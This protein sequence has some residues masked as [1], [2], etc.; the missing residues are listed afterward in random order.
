MNNRNKML[1]MMPNSEME[2]R[3]RNEMENRFR[4]RRGREHYNN[5]RYAPRR[6]SAYD[7]YGMEDAYDAYD[8]EGYEMEERYEMEEMEGYG[9]GGMQPIGFSYNEM[10]GYNRNMGGGGKGGKMERGG[11]MGEEE[12]LTKR[13]ITEWLKNMKNADGSKGAH[14]QM[15]QTEQIRKQHNIEC[16]PADFSIAMN[17]MYSD[18]CGVAKKLNVN[19]GQFYALMAKAFLDDEDSGVEDKLAA[20]YFAIVQ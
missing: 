16:D 2:N 20:Y 1:Y 8:M 3:R 7:E 15:E 6:R 11:S 12:E 5:G 14:W 4:D 17:M 10:R 9:R 18:Y 13:D 19:N